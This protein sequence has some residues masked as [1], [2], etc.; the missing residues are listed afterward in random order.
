MITTEE[1]VITG[2]EDD[3]QEPWE[4]RLES[5]E[6]V[7]F[8]GSSLFTPGKKKLFFLLLKHHLL[9]WVFCLESRWSSGWVVVVVEIPFASSSSSG[10]MRLDL[11][12]AKV[13]RHE[14]MGDGR[15]RKEE[16]T[17]GTTRVGSPKQ[18]FLPWV[19]FTFLWEARN[20]QSSLV[21][22]H[23]KRWC[24]WWWR[25]CWWWMEDW[26]QQLLILIQ[27]SISYCAPFDWGW[28]MMVHMI[29]AVIIIRIDG[30]EGWWENTSTFF[31]HHH[32]IQI[33][34]GER[35]PLDGK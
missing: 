9:K 21:S 31:K 26:Y 4:V 3:Q 12:H 19:S 13:K 32:T 25:C 33:T 2:G 16:V 35:E 14:M 22:L 27:P 34:T 23:E 29:I 18:D 10:K 15:R 24:D 8:C 5:R 6:T 28:E 1:M 17:N 20:S 7:L 11:R 30:E